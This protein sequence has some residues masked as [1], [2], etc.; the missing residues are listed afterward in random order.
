[1]KIKLQFAIHLATFLA[2]L[3]TIPSHLLCQEPAPD[4]EIRAAS[5]KL[6]DAFN[7][8]K[9]ADVSA[10]FLSQGEVIDEQG[11]LFQGQ[12]AVQELLTTYFEKFPGVK[13]EPTIES[14]RMAG[15]VAIEEGFRTTVTNDGGIAQVQYTIIY[16][17]TDQGWKVASIRD[18]ALNSVVSP[19]ELLQP[20]EWLV[21]EWINEGADA[22]V[23]LT[24][25][26]SEDGNFILG[27]ILVMK[28]EQPVIKSTQRICWDPR[29]SK[30]RSWT[31]DSDGGF[32]E[33][34]WTQIDNAW[35]VR[36]DAVLPNGE[37]GSANVLITV[38]ENGR[39]VMKGTNR[40]VGNIVEDDYEITVVKQPPAA[41]K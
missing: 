9:A 22:R 39:Y 3:L 35:S 8:G 16:S 15:P 34:V 17:K 33:S 23:K 28:S 36:S 37:T 4:A 5:K 18:T 30:P 38:G 32:T 24:Y 29:A 14:I 27:E 12:K 1:M 19:G 25:Q 11:N 10:M 40:I 2:G 26:W 20:L 7:A 13:S 6:T 31:F 21:G 41:T